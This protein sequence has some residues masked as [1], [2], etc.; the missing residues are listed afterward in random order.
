ML[1]TVRDGSTADT[2]MTQ[3]AQMGIVFALGAEARTAD[4]WQ[5][6]SRALCRITG[7]GETLAANGARALLAAGASVLVSWGTSGA[8][9]DPLQP[10]QILL[11]KATGRLGEPRFAAD[12]HWL[13]SCEQAL[14]PMNPRLVE[15]CTV[16]A[17]L[18]GAGAKRRLG[19]R[20][21]C[22]AVDMESAAVA[23]VAAAAG[24][25]FLGIR[26]VVDPMPFEIPAAAIA[27]MGADGTTS[28]RKVLAALCR[29]PTDLPPLIRLGWHF[30][31]A[32]EALTS[33]AT[34][35]AKAGLVLPP[36][37]GCR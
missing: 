12:P 23:A 4:R 2:G 20:S 6:A 8:L 35:L 11:L 5:R 29:R 10:G 15:A 34:L 14:A 3:G 22:D 16:R 19:E 1:G 30:R 9:T 18:T 24:V 26:A 32:L 25:P 28:P 36:A 17:P 37:S 31:Q 27:G 33:A 7:P 21:H 13:T